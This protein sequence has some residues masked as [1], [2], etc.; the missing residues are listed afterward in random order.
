MKIDVATISV[1]IVYAKELSAAILKYIHECDFPGQISKLPTTLDDKVTAEAEEI[2]VTAGYLYKLYEDIEVTLARLPI[3]P[4]TLVTA[5]HVYAL[6]YTMAKHFDVHHYDDGHHLSHLLYSR[7]VDC[8]RTAMH[9]RE[10]QTQ[11]QIT[12]VV[13]TV[14]LTNNPPC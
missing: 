13:P 6:Y 9:I 8:N 3:Y 10:Q 5:N 1:S 7:G 2:C 4:I 14:V 11:M 12:I